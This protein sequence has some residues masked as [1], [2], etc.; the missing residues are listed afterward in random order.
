MLI[1]V[2]LLWLASEMGVLAIP[3]INLP[4]LFN[5]WPL[6]L[7]MTGLHMLVG[8]RMHWLRAL[9]DVFSVVLV[10]GLV[11]AGP[12][13]GYGKDPSIKT[14]EISEDIRGASSAVLSVSAGDQV[15][16]LKPLE[17]GDSRLLAGALKDFQPVDISIEGERERF[18]SIN[19]QPFNFTLWMGMPPEE[20]SRWDLQFNP[21]IPFDIELTL[22]GG[23]SDINLQQAVLKALK[24]ESGSGSTVL[25]LPPPTANYLLELNSGSGKMDI[26]LPKDAPVHLELLDKGSG[27]LIRPDN[28]MTMKMQHSQ[29]GEWQ[30]PNFR[31]G[32]PHI[33][34]QIINMSSG[35][36]IFH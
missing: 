29:Q 1:G 32:E 16:T 36:I 7:V 20:T 5:L 27:K 12:Q 26:Y 34:I 6:L 2:G 3:P 11:L 31:E 33:L 21:A 23:S 14:H 22:N 4:M 25:R 19:G 15:L 18:I 9:L 8:N 30:T 13:L 35:D 28:F 10:F 24:I 17:A